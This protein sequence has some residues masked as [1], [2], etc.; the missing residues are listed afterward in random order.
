MKDLEEPKS[1][2]SEEAH[3]YA[4]QFQPLDILET[5]KRSELR[6]AGCGASRRTPEQMEA[7]GC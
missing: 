7:E 4:A 6:P 1:A 2:H 5:P 3:L